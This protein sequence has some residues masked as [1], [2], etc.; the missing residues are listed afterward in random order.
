M[1]LPYVT[2]EGFILHIIPISPCRRRKTMKTLARTTMC[3]DLDPRTPECHAEALRAN[4]IH[5]AK[6]RT[7]SKIHSCPTT[8]S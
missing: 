5:S 3:P 6:Q 7:V 8:S 1:S 2:G 4:L